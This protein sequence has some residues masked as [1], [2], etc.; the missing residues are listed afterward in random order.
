MSG[1]PATD[2]VT[3]L[4]PSGTEPVVLAVIWATVDIERVLAGIGLTG[5]EV[6][7]DRLLGATVRLVRPPAAEPIALLEPRTEGRIAAT[8]AQSGEGPAGRYVAT[9][10]GFANVRA[11]AD[12]AGIALS[13]EDDG[14]FGR[15]VLVL[16]GAPA[17]PHLVLVDRPA[18]TIER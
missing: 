18:G 15:S 17:G 7:D 13:R 11:R 2:A 6:P 14:P 12:A 1:S 4:L 16:G 9:M 5:E 8:L 10:D 3:L